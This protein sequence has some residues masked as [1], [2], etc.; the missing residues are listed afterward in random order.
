MVLE[1]KKLVQ[2]VKV[3]AG[4]LKN[5][6]VVIQNTYRFLRLNHLYA[7]WELYEDGRLAE[8]GKLLLPELAPMEE[9]TVR[10]PYHCLGKAGCEY[11]VECSFRLKEAAPWS[12]A[13]FE[14]AYGIIIYFS[15]PKTKL[16][17]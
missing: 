8:S 9:K 4:N 12:E 3:R 5:Q 1:F 6:E 2:P 10:I 15:S 11:I 13:G 7:V 14:I 16:T 17:D